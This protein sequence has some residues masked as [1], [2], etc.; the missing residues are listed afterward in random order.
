VFWALVES[1]REASAALRGFLVPWEALKPVAN[2][3]VC[4]RC[5]RAAA[6]DKF[7]LQLL[8]LLSSV[9]TESNQV[10]PYI[11]GSMWSPGPCL[12]VKA[13]KDPVDTSAQ[14]AHAPHQT[15]EQKE[16]AD[17]LNMVMSISS[18]CAVELGSGKA[19]QSCWLCIS[20][21]RTIVRLV[22]SIDRYIILGLNIYILMR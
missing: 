17:T 21:D 22:R 19:S 13:S 7:L 4:G 16:S 9:Y 5:S 6:P 18:H 3:H 8:L 2:V 11:L 15:T 12:A 1:N 20:A 14:A 10:L